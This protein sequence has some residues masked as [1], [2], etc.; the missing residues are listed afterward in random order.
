MALMS[1]SPGGLS[2]LK[3]TYMLLHLDCPVA[4]IFPTAWIASPSYCSPSPQDKRFLLALF[5]HIPLWYMKTSAWNSAAFSK[6]WLSEGRKKRRKDGSM[7]NCFCPESH[8]RPD[9]W[10]DT[11]S[12]PRCPCKRVVHAQRFLHLGA[13]P[14]VQGI[15]GPCQ[16]SS[17]TS[18]VQNAPGFK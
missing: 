15:V 3:L 16:V 17:I 2:H 5:L 1:C 18:P 9:P 11:E 4:S 10:Q 8:S 14:K 7:F 12:R 13:V 6:H